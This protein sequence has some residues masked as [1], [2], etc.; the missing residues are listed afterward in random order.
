MF[1]VES[2]WLCSTGCCT[3]VDPDEWFQRTTEWPLSTDSTVVEVGGYEGRWAKTVQEQYHPKLF[4][5]EP[6]RW[7]YRICRQK[8][9]QTGAKV[10]NYGLGDRNLERESMGAWHTDGASFV[11]KTSSEREAFGRIREIG[12]V[13]SELGL[14][15]V[16]LLSM[17]CEGYEMILLPHMLKTGLL[18]HIRWLQVQF[19]L[20]GDGPFTGEHLQEILEGIERTH[21]RL[22]GGAFI[23]WERM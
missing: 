19:H 18:S 21:R 20:Y 6:Q 5:F 11:R 23:A 1:W 9:W 15:K 17:N 22:W 4:V 8:L 3:R 12:E 13:F 7:A 16:D 10:L 2:G 14:G